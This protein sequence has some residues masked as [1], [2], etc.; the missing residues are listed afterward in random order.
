MNMYTIISIVIQVYNSR[1]P[2]LINYVVHVPPPTENSSCR[3][4]GRS[5]LRWAC[6]ARGR[7][8]FSRLPRT[9]SPRSRTTLL[10]PSCPISV[11]Q[12]HA[13][14]F[15]RENSGRF[16]VTC[17]WALSCLDMS[18]FFLCRS[19]YRGGGFHLVVCLPWCEWTRAGSVGN[20]FAVWNYWR[21][22]R[23]YVW[24]PTNRISQSTGRIAPFHTVVL[25]SFISQNCAMLGFSLSGFLMW[26]SAGS[27]EVTA[28]RA[29]FWYM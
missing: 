14:L 3:Y 24:L 5:Y 2:L 9:P 19:V 1:R 8:L 12:K 21:A 25:A 7:A 16:F 18:Q 4:P 23:M 15:Y 26:P 28:R 20:R 10:P 29:G 17:F 22:G 11:S 13:T 6:L 27:C